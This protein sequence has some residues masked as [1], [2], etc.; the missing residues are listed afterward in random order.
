[1][2]SSQTYRSR[3]LRRLGAIAAT[4]LIAPALAGPPAADDKGLLILP[5]VRIV[6]APIAAPKKAPVATSQGM[7]AAI[8]PETG[9]LRQ[10]TAEDAAALAP[11][12]ARSA[13]RGAQR[14][15]TAE[16]EVGE[17]LY[18]PGNAIG[19]TLGEDAMVYQVAKK[20]DEGVELEEVYGE[21]AATRAVNAASKP[22]ST[23]NMQKE[24][25]HARK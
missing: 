9:R 7:R 24:A 19:V 6:N 25:A 5:N 3:W 2:H 15:A 22:A 21:K 1:M 12:K 23:Q 10:V 17:M 13:A 20:V 11:A 14:T 18:G 16:P 4:S 8:D